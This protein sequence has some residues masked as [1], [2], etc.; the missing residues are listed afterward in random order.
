M[1]AP[2]ELMRPDDLVILMVDI[3]ACPFAERTANWRFTD[4][5]TSTLRDDYPIILRN[6]I[7]QQLEDTTWLR[8]TGN[9]IP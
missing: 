7:T 3:D 6:Y 1:S 2:R 9:V 5:K 8:C 4:V